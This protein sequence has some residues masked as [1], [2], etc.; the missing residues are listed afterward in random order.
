MSILNV[1]TNKTYGYEDAFGTADCSSI[2]MK[3]AIEEWFRLFYQDKPDKFG[4]PCQR[5][6]YTVVNKL[7]KTMFGE[8]QATGQDD[9]ASS[10]LDGLDKVRKRL[11][12]DFMIGGI[13][14]IKPFPLPDRFVFSSVSRANMLIFGTDVEGNP[15]DVGTAERTVS[16]SAYYTLLERRTIGADGKLTIRNRL[17]RSEYDS[18]IG[19][20]VPL[21]SIPRYEAL[22][23]EYTYPEDVGLGMV[24]L[25]CPVPNCVD[26]SKDPVSVY[27][28]AVGLIRSINRNEAELSGEFERGKSRLI[29]A[30]DMLKPSP[31]GKHKALTDEV[32]TA[33][34]DDP[35]TV[36]IT[37]F[38][39]A[40]R[41]QSFLARKAEYLRNVESVIGLKRGVLSEV[42]AMDKTATEVTSSAGDYNLTIIDFQQAWESAVRELMPLCGKLGRLYRV[43]GAH[44]LTEDSV[45]IDWGNGVLYDEDKTWADYMAMVAAGLIKPEI[46]VGWRFNMP[47]DKPRDLEKIRAKYMPTLDNL[48]ETPTDEQIPGEDVPESTIDQAEEAAGKTLNGAQTQ[49]LI[50]I[51]AQYQTG[52]LTM[53]QAVNI[54]SIAIGITKDEAKAL[55]EG[56]I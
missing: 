42:E 17:F 8:Y 37:A 40:L 2:Y 25:R 49:S 5:I 35:E 54:L 23:E 30:S 21:N 50:S 39:P 14:Y 12:H 56:A 53:G 18:Q 6:P 38:S 41:E 45:T 19:R 27:A 7:T 43:A 51:I 16:G 32:F 31:D 46:A 55:V 4:D 48:M 33:F 10:V 36:G 44:D 1:I 3:D 34:D 29:V 9:F 13:S 22:P 24:A 26:G 28:A 52:T 20:P 47:T 15:T 11:A